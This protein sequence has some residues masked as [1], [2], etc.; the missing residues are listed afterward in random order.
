MTTLPGDHLHVI[1][2]H[3]YKVNVTLLFE[4][5]VLIA[6]LLPDVI[7]GMLLNLFRP[8]V[9]MKPHFTVLTDCFEIF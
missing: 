1:H 8:P 3:A 6:F 2:V 5:L 4:N 9:N 7:I